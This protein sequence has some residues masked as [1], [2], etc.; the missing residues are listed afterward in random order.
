MPS[1]TQ[2]TTIHIIGAGVSGLAC[3]WELAQHGHTVQVFEQ[4]NTLGAQAC[5]WYAGGMLAPW[6]ERENAE[7]PVQVWGEQ[8]IAWWA[9]HTAVQRQGSLVVAHG[10]DYPALKQFA[11]RTTHYQWLD[12]AQ[13]AELEPALS[14]GLQRALFFPAEA[15]LTPRQALADLLHAVQ[16]AGVTVHFGRSYP[17][18]AAPTNTLTLDCRGFSARAALPQLRG[19]KGEMLRIRSQDVTLSRPIRLLHPRHPI[20]IVPHGD[21]TYMVGATVL[22]SEDRQ[23]ISARSLLELLNTLCSLHPA[24]GEAE[25]LETGSALRPAFP[26]NLPQLVRTAP[27]Y[28]HLN[29]FYR[30]GYLLAPILAQ[31]TAH[32]LLNPHSPVNTPEPLYAAFH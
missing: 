26:N 27:R 15:H 8:A 31:H 17:P 5:S 3:A 32:Y 24:L 28:W 10:R 23:R 2:T 1:Q 21:H 14:S 4:A 18:S 25:V 30:H 6:C 16:T 11:Q 12:A 13:L 20:Y 7:A 19:V 22:E 29:G 9:Q